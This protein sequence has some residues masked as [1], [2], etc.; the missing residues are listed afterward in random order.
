MTVDAWSPTQYE[1]FRDERSRPFMDLLS[2]VRPSPA[3]RVIDLGCGTGELTLAMHLKLGAKSTLGIDSSEAMLERS[4]REDAPPGLSFAKG[5][6]AEIATDRAGQPYDLVFSN[7][8]LHWVPDHRALL[9]GL[10]ARVAAKGQLAVQV[11]ANFDHASH[12]TAAEVAA[13][14][15]FAEALR[16]C[17]QTVHVL[18]PEAY[19]SILYELG[20]K[21][22]H[23]RL[24]VYGHELGATEDIVEWVKGTLLTPY[25]SRLPAPLY[26]AF[27]ARYRERLLAV[28]GAHRPYFF[29]FKRI[30]FWGA[31]G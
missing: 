17:T 15:P 25:A 12:T 22:Q 28:L 11:P 27:V 26:D 24:V 2:L 6:I 30:L 16:G 5:D 10:A 13:E 7:A 29:A 9:A 19:A 8:A 20:F 18:A 3:M 14:A 21:E 1:R 31:R 4:R 23:V